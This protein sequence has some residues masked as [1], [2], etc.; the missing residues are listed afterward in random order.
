MVIVKIYLH[1]TKFYEISDPRKIKILDHLPCM[2]SFTIYQLTLFWRTGRARYKPIEDLR[3]YVYKND[4]NEKSLYFKNKRLDNLIFSD[5]SVIK[6]FMEEAKDTYIYNISEQDLY[7]KCKITKEYMQDKEILDRFYSGYLY[8]NLIYEKEINNQ[9]I[10]FNVNDIK[11]A[12][13]KNKFKEYMM[14]KLF[15]SF[16]KILNY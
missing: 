15:G 12:K 7:L 6:I 1:H 3:Y 9:I 5:F 14:Q 8:C 13:K 4:Q 2:K 16:A 10:D 11:I